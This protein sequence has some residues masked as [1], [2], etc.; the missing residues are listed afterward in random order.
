MWDQNFEFLLRGQLPFPDA[1]VEFEEDTDL[2]DLGLDSLGVVELLEEL[3][4]V[5]G[6]ECVNVLL[7]AENFTTVGYLWQTVRAANP[8]DAYARTGRRPLDARFQG[9]AHPLL[10]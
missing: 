3:E 5:Y 10:R 2:R 8:T 6:V 1:D 7:G 9:T 4:K